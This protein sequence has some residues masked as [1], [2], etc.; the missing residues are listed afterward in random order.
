MPP[1]AGANDPARLPLDTNDSAA[2]VPEQGASEAPGSR[3]SSSSGHLSV[4]PARLGG[5]R[6]LARGRR[7][8]CRSM[9]DRKRC[10]PA[11]RCVGLPSA[12]TVGSVRHRTRPSAPAMPTTG[13]E[14]A[15]EVSQSTEVPPDSSQPRSGAWR[16]TTRAGSSGTA[17][18]Q[19]ASGIATM[20]LLS[21]SP[22]PDQAGSASRCLRECTY[23]C[24]GK[25]AGRRAPDLE[26]RLSAEPRVAYKQMSMACPWGA[27]ER[28]P[29]GMPAPS[30][31]PLRNI[32]NTCGVRDGQKHRTSLP[33]R[34]GRCQ[35]GQA[36]AERNTPS[37]RGYEERP[38]AAS[39][40]A[41]QV[42]P[43]RCRRTSDA[44]H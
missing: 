26:A 31:L 14:A 5:S 19:V 2:A 16:V 21:S 38:G 28:R 40:E 42:V 43:D 29:V 23:M 20:N 33:T 17:A 27:D 3:Q 4:T 11:Q 15:E 7:P 6:V 32:Q 18:A 35:R 36:S 12:S 22:H 44:R 30:G 1:A 41:S 39:S 10:D 25:E 9:T 24:T 37:P 13:S 34:L 8:R